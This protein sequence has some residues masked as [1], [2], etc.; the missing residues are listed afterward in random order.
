M[1]LDFSTLCA[2]NWERSWGR[3]LAQLSE[4]NLFTRNPE[5]LGEAYRALANGEFRFAVGQEF[6]LRLDGAQLI[7]CNGI[8]S[9]GKI[10]APPNSLLEAVAY[11]N[12]VAVGT[13]Q[14]VLVEG[15][16]ANVLVS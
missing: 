3:N 7:V 10:D 1:G 2:P 4:P 8:Q 13:V 14:S 5:M 9:I 6:V 15:R 12:G 11:G 16:A